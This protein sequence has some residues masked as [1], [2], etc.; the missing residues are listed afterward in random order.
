MTSANRN[1]LKYLVAL[2][3]ILAVVTIGFVFYRSVHLP[4]SVLAM[5]PTPDLDDLEEQ[6][7]GE[8]RNRRIA[9]EKSLDS[10]EDWG[11]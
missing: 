9:V 1:L 3:A 8:I 6:V 4:R 2:L 10:A 11:R 5:L 7:A